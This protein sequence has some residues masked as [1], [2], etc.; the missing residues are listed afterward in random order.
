MV[1][2]AVRCDCGFVVRSSDDERLV[3]ELQEHA[4]EH[5]GMHLSPEQVLAMAEIE[6]HDPKAGE[7]R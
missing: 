2:K 7:R 3:R 6:E 5:H 1:T 4:R